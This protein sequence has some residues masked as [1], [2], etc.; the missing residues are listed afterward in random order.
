MSL[1]TTSNLFLNRSR[2]GDSTTS[3]GSL[4]VF[5]HPFCK[6]VFFSDIQPKP[7]LVQL[8]AISPHPLTCHQ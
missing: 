7:P 3:L 8:Q 2:D 4:F 1:G 6:E 5:N